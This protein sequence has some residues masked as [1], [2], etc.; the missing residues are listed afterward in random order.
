[1]EHPLKYDILKETTMIR[2]KQLYRLLS[3][4]NRKYYG[5]YSSSIMFTC[6]SLSNQSPVES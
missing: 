6:V 4:H 5:T 1:M 3:L 2:V